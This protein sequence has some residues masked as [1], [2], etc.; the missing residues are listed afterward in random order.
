MRDQENDALSGKRTLVVRI[1][2]KAAKFYHVT[3]I[4]LSL[5]FSLIY[6]FIYFSSVYQYLFF[7]TVPLFVLNIRE[8][9]R[10]T[11]PIELNAELKKLA[12]STFAFSV[13]FGI[14]LI[15]G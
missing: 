6:S 2:A 7:I 9:I 13:T 11:E 15:L 12:L 14:G 5:L 3:L 10:N 4:S 8:V 1:G